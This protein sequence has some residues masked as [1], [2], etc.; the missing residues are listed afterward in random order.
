[1]SNTSSSV[2]EGGLRR[3]VSKARIG[4]VNLKVSDLERSLAFYEGILEFKITKRIGNDAAFLAYGDYHHDICINTWQSRAGS[5]PPEGTTGLFHLAIVYSERRD[6]RE[7]F[8]RLK[9]AGV[10][11]DSVIDHGVSESIYIR[12]PDQNGVELYWDRPAV[13]WWDDAGALRM[14]HR[15]MD[16]EELLRDEIAPPAGHLD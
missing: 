6:L 8:A 1:M 14:G 15:P 2:D 13:G 12:D 4:H 9:T 10:T 16:P 11:I 3:H 5:P 7:A